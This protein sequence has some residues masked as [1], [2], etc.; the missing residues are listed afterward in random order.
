MDLNLIREHLDSIDSEITRLFVERMNTV[1]EVA[2][3]KKSS[4]KAIRDHARELAIIHRI[5]EQAGETYAPYIEDLYKLIFELSRSYQA[6]LLGVSSALGER[7]CSACTE[8]TERKLP[9]HAQVACLISEEPQARQACEQLISFPDILCFD[10]SDDV[11]N[12]VENGNCQYGILSIESSAAGSATQ[13]YDRL[14]KHSFHIVGAT[15]QNNTRFLCISRSMEIY[16][17]ARKISFAC[18][19][20]HESVSLNSILSRLIIAGAYLCRMENQPIP[21]SKSRFFFD[22]DADPHDPEII[23]LICELE[24]CTDN[25]AFLGAYEER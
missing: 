3:F 7:L 2:A 8:C 16:P 1:G 15:R 14:E 13:V 17:N 18:A 5:T 24:S 11:F 4:G 22:I 25:F 23:R 6:K 20:P 9:T 12:A 19:L 21:D 10:T